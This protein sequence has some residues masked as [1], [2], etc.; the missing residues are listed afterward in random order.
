MLKI[1]VI[2]ASKKELL[3]DLQRAAE[4]DQSAVFR[5]VYEEEYRAFGGEPF[6]AL[7]GDCEFSNSS[8]GHGSRRSHVARVGGG[9]CAI[10]HGADP[11]LFGLDS[12]TKLDQPRDLAEI[13]D[14]T[15][16]VKWKSFQ[17]SED[18]RY[19]GLCL[20]HI[21]TREP[22]GKETRMVEE[23]DYE[24][25]VGSDH[26]KYLWGN[27]AYAFAT[28]LTEAF[29]KYGWCATIRGVEGGGLVEGLPTHNYKTD[30]GDTVLKCPTE[31][32]ITDRR[33]KELGDLGL[34]PLVHCK[35][36]DYA[37]FFSA[38][39]RRSRKLSPRRCKRARLSAQL[40]YL[41]ATSRFAH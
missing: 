20:P 14:M 26:S 11:A 15:E 21:L 1:R 12:F 6:A 28:R 10:H 17:D 5:K 3:R 40:P 41:F 16:Y 9:A 37:A 33:E 38:H 34:M 29:A 35:G 25:R 19:V 23:F 4:F 39:P 13:F 36:N 8:R 2:N 32:Q 22:Y 27:A 18:S 30:E 24:E 31:V 7:I